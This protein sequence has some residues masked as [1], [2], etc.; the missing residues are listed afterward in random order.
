M[1]KNLPVLP[2]RETIILPSLTEQISVGRT[3]SVAAVLEAYHTSGQIILAPQKEGLKLEIAP[4]DL[5]NVGVLCNIVQVMDMPDGSMRVLFESISRVT[6]TSFQVDDIITCNY[7]VIPDIIQTN[8]KV[9]ESAFLKELKRSFDKLG[10]LQSIPNDIK[11][12]VLVSNNLSTVTDLIS[13]YVFLK[14]QDRLNCLSNSKVLD[15]AQSALQQIKNQIEI[16]ETQSKI[17]KQ[18]DDNISK[19]QKIYFLEEQKAA[20]EKELSDLGGE[21]SEIDEIKNKITSVELPED[22]KSKCLKE[23]KRL[24]GLQPMSSEAGVIRSYLDTILSL[25]WGKESVDN[26][27]LDNAR[28]ILD[29][30]HF[31]MDKVKDRIIE[32]LAIMS[33]NKNANGI[34]LLLDGSAGTG[35]SSIAK[36]IAKSLGREFVR[37]S[38]GGVRDESEIRGHRRTYVGSLPGK[39]IAAFKKSKTMNPLILLD[40]IDKMSN[41]FKGDPSSAMLEVLDPVQNKEFVD[42][43]LDLDFDLSKVLFVATSNYIG[44]IQKPLVDRMEVIKVDNYLETEKIAIARDYF[45][46]KLQVECGLSHV[47]INFTNEA[48]VEL[49][50]GYTAEGGVRNLERKVKTI[51]RKIAKQ[52]ATTKTKIKSITVT[53]KLVN[54]YLDYKKIEWGTIEKTPQVG[55]VNGMAYSEG[56][57]DLLQVEAVKSIGGTGAVLSTGKLGEVMKESTNVAFTCAKSLITDEKLIDK[58]NIHVHFPDGATPKDGP[59]AGI[60]LVTAFVSCLTETPV[61]NTLSMTGEVTIRG[62]VLAIGGVKEKVISAH[63][64]GIKEVILP[65]SN[66]KDVKDIPEEI[67]KDITFHFVDNIKDVLKISLTKKPEGVKL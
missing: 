49:V 29:N 30:E 67:A 56:G 65:K 14:F 28:S 20:I 10:K 40:E 44:N 34:T 50:R 55:L 18:V 24:K 26:F 66:K 37:V 58:I 36:S 35:K 25:P 57:G 8:E 9:S 3:K 52:V 4:E 45:C 13:S 48:L 17:H 5:Y 47:S 12:K 54:E 41:D 2:L 64:G 59:S 33:L 51:Y 21:P 19:S 7:T 32:Q 63:R 61:K 62:K 11:A 53:P 6:I 23:L 39:I 15:R 16:A 60:A 46:K 38:L 43:Y 22:V 1:N 42:H 27:D 31:G